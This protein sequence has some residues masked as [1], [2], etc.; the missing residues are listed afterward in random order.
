MGRLVLLIS[1]AVLALAPASAYADGGAESSSA[2]I[3]A[4]A[5]AVQA[6]AML[7]ANMGAMDARVRVQA[8]LGA[9]DQQDVRIDRLR[10]ADVALGR[11]DTAA[12]RRELEA[13]FNP[14]DRH[15]IGTRFTGSGNGRVAA[16]ILGAIVI[17]AAL[18][19]LLRQMRSNATFADDK[20]TRPRRKGF[21]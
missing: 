10:A 20:Q 5:L 15:L 11:N 2:D 4:Q 19:L 21:T 7:D 9:K 8:A 6:L 3:P 1:A 12:A 17:A 16:A 14:D 18:L 13:A